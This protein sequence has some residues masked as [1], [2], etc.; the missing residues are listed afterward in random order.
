MQKNKVSKNHISKNKAIIV[1][2]VAEY[3][4]VYRNLPPDTVIQQF[5]KT[6]QHAIQSSENHIHA[7]FGTVLLS[8]GREARVEVTIDAAV[9][10]N[11]AN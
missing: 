5:S 6:L 4:E 2:D 3:P 11:I 10:P 9:I 7:L 8:D 1:F